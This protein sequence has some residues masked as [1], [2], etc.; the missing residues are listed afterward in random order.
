MAGGFSLEKEKIT[1]F[2]DLLIKNFTKLKLDFSKNFNLYLDSIIAPSAVNEDFF[3]D[4]N[5]LA[6]FGSGNNE[7]KF[8]VEDVKIISSIVIAGKH[9]KLKILGKD[10][11]VFSSFLWNG[12]NGPLE[13]FLNKSNKKKIN[14][15]GKMRLNDWKGK[16]NVD[17]VIEDVS[18][19]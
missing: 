17:F 15:A 7:P 11:S 9:I 3:Q 1:E 4:I 16:K 19:N 14:I 5:T 12:I 13:P 18:L 8:V 6:P 2:R 10:G